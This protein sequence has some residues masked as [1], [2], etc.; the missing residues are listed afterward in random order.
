[1]RPRGP[2]RDAFA[3]GFPTTAYRFRAGHHIRLA[4]GSSCWPM[5]W[6]SPTAASIRVEGGQ[7]LLPRLAE[8]PRD[9]SR[10]L[11]SPVDL[12]ATKS[13]EVIETPRL[14]RF[15]RDLDDGTLFSGWHQ[16]YSAL[17]YR[18]TGVTFGHETR[19]EHGLHPDDPLTARSTFDHASCATGPT[20]RH[21][22]AAGSPRA[23]PRRNSDWRSPDGGMGRRAG[24][25]TPLGH[26]AR[27][28]V[29]GDA[30]RR[31][32]PMC[33][34]NR[35][36][37]I[38]G[39]CSRGKC[40]TRLLPAVALFA[41]LILPP[42]RQPPTC[43]SLAW[44][45]PASSPSCATPTRREPVIPQG[46]RSTTAPPSAISMQA[47]GNRHERSGRRFAPLA[48]PSTGSSPA[49]VPL[50]AHRP[51]P[52]RGSGRGF[53][54]AQL[55]LPKPG[56][57]RAADRGNCGNSWSASRQE[58]SLFSSL[59]TPCLPTLPRIPL[60][61]VSYDVGAVRVALQTPVG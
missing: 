10:P 1:M 53:A 19:A 16:P 33:S 59:T 52:R 23:R 58:R 45:S 54:R 32:A 2:G 15:S 21:W 27:S 26:L 51:A 4:V 35:V 42:G 37:A 49:N 17:R 60:S 20:A 22:S 9:L 39:R 24:E 50:S 11:P 29:F 36:S 34:R 5:V 8:L 40:M 25:R 30:A 18:D 13:W 41:A 7:L 44:P 48:W 38:M 28:P 12:P 57:R 46:S 6:P 47:A 55:V 61:P 3:S 14:E 31:A 56:P 43:G